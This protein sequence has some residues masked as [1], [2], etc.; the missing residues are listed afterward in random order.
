MYFK[1]SKIQKKRKESSKKTPWRLKIEEL[2]TGRVVEYHRPPANGKESGERN[3]FARKRIITPFG[4]IPITS[5]FF[6]FTKR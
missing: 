2:D 3:P 1:A 6:S 5:I 4:G